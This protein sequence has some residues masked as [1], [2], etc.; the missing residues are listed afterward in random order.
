MQNRRKK[1]I[2][3]QIHF[4]FQPFQISAVPW[5]CWW[6]GCVSGCC[7][8]FGSSGISGS[9]PEVCIQQGNAVGFVKPASPSE[10]RPWSLTLETSGDERESPGGH[11]GLGVFRGQIRT[12]SQR[13][14]CPAGRCFRSWPHLKELIVP[15][16]WEEQQLGGH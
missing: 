2:L 15:P 12:V 10:H 3:N 4:C 7:E 14:L 16:G 5:L 13:L 1:I 8:K 9:S 6:K 11:Q